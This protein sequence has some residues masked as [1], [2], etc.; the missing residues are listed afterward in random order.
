MQNPP[1]SVQWMPE[2]T[3]VEKFWFYFH[4]VFIRTGFHTLFRAITLS[5]IL[6]GLLFILGIY[7]NF[8]KNKSKDRRT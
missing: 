6:F 2:T 1:V 8:F 3:D 7:I 4:F 5:L